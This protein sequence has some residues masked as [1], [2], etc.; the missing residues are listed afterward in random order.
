MPTF[1]VI[2][3]NGG[4]TIAEATGSRPLCDYCDWYWPETM[5][6]KKRLT[7]ELVCERHL[8]GAPLRMCDLFLRATGADD[9]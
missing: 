1:R 5:I 6:L 8:K 3:Q 7:V 2:G 4:G 9:E